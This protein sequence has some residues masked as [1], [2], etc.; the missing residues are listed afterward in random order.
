LNP[1]FNRREKYKNGRAVRGGSPESVLVRKGG[2]IVNGFG[3][4]ERKRRSERNLPG[5]VHPSLKEM[6]KRF[7]GGRGVI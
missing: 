7:A 3:T 1:Q 4:A 5:T 2:R 6:R